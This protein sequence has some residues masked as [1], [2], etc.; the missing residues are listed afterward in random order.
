ML[1]YRPARPDLTV[2]M[3]T[4]KKNPYCLQLWDMRVVFYSFST[5]QHSDIEINRYFFI[6]E[7]ILDF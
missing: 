3:G 4:G 6:F 1:V 2:S 7:R 5:D